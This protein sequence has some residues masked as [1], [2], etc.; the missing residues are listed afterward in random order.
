MFLGLK[1]PRTSVRSASGRSIAAIS[2]SIRGARS[3]MAA[4][5]GP[6]IGIDPQLLEEARVGQRAAQGGVRPGRFVDGPQDRTQPAGDL[7]IG[8]AFHQQRLP[9]DRVVGRAGHREEVVRPVLEQ[10][11]GDR[12]RGQDL[13]Q[14][15]Q[16]GRLGPDPVERGEPLHR[17]AEPLAAL[18]DDEGR[19]AVDVN[20]QHDVGDAAGQLADAEVGSFRDCAPYFASSRPR[21]RRRFLTL[22]DSK[23]QN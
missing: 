6:V 8:R 5:D 10:D 4:G 19:L 17:H 23:I 7:G 16:R 13:L 21:S 15:P 3:G 2:A 12:P 14:D 18:L 20:P 22:F 1:S 11:P 9:G